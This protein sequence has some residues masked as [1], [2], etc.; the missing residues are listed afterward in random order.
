MDTGYF[1]WCR[2]VT[3]E[4][5]KG[6]QLRLRNSI[7]VYAFVLLF[8]L[9][10]IASGCGG[11]QSDEEQGGEKQ[12]GSAQQEAGQGTSQAKGGTGGEQGGS[13]AQTKTAVGEVL[14]VNTERRRFAIKPSKGDLIDFK[15][16]PKAQ[17][18]LDG[19]EVELKAMKKG[20]S[21]QIRY[22]VKD[23]G[24]PNRAQSIT[25][26]SNGAGGGGGTG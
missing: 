6:G 9:G 7:V 1:G 18:E 8:L 2:R 16:L 20:Q 15:A 24:V 11:G 25:L 23:T 26:F 19:K 14:A 10:G 21:V 13:A 22:V 5:S 12:G 3:Y 4:A 17:I